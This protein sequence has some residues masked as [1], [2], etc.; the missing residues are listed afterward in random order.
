MVPSAYPRY[1]IF[2]CESTSFI[3]SYINESGFSF[4]ERYEHGEKYGSLMVKENLQ[5]ENFNEVR[6]YYLQQKNIDKLL[7][8][9]KY[10]SVPYRTLIKISE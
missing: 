1:K 4:I 10:P 8:L 6:D 2:S 9:G 3:L 5:F 7:S